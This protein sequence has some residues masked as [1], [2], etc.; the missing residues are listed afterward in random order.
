MI[1]T[2]IESS[3]RFLL[4]EDAEFILL[5][6][7]IRRTRVEYNKIGLSRESSILIAG[8]LLGLSSDE[9]TAILSRVDT[10]LG[11]K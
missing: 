7:N 6:M 4:G 8:D 5:V 10:K 9:T 3:L 1:T 11:A 2:D